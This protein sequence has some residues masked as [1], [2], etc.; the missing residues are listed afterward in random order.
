[1]VW[2][3]INYYHHSSENYGLKSEQL[4]CFVKSK[5]LNLTMEVS[6][7]ICI[8]TSSNWNLFAIDFDGINIDWRLCLCRVLVCDKG[9]KVR[10]LKISDPSWDSCATFP[11]WTISE[12]GE[13]QRVIFLWIPSEW[14]NCDE[15]EVR[16]ILRS[17]MSLA[18][19]AKPF[20]RPILQDQFIKGFIKLEDQMCELNYRGAKIEIGVKLGDQRYNFIYK[21]WSL[22]RKPFRRWHVTVNIWG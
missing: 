20:K 3:T 6:K 7:S 16:D 9:V 21:K 19:V 15:K 8:N 2:I 18:L 17:T 4:A 5:G 12:V 13:R 11:S 14:K 10:D 1:V 22:Y